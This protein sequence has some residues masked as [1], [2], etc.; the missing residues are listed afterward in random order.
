[1]IRI[2]H[3]MDVHR[4]SDDPARPLVLAGI[5]IDGSPGLE[6]HSDADVATH[7][8]CDAV[9]GAAGLGDLGRHFPDADPAFAGVPSTGLL[10]ECVSLARAEGLIVSSGDVTIV[11]ETPKLAAYF[12][13]MAARLTE[14]VSAPVSVK[15]TTTEGL[16]SIGRSEGI[17]AHAVVLLSDP[18]GH[19]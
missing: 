3:G 4:F 14:V 11:A 9:L 8:L 7:A 19:P 2:G 16:G 6:G 18:A 17:A 1:M 10:A 15:A 13:A 5:V 12:D